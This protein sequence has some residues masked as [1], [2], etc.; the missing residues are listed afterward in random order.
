MS[1]RIILAGTERLLKPMIS[2]I[3]ALHQLL[4]YKDIGTVYG[5]PVQGFQELVK[6]RPQ[7]HLYF[8]QADGLIDSEFGATR[9]RLSFRIMNESAETMTPD[10]ALALAKKINS[11]FGGNS[12]FYW[13]KGKHLFS[14]HAP[15]QGMQTKIYTT[16]EA[17]AKQVVKK[18]LGL[19]NFTVDDDFLKDCSRTVDLATP[20]D[21]GQGKEMI[22]GE[23][24]RLPRKLP[25][26]RVVFTY[27]E[28]LLHGLPNAVCL[29]DMTGKKHEPLI[30][31][32]LPANMQ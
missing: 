26:S 27:A 21:G 15:H 11:S 22:Y 32:Y 17:E 13:E 29:V 6:F 19:Q 10:K 30:R 16:N 8:E 2:Q 12:P 28:M 3:M 20:Q 23:S 14:Y 9:A 24:R 7:I 1:D 31:G 4:Q 18:I 25:V 5:T